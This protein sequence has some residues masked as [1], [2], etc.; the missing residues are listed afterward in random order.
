[1]LSVQLFVD[2]HYNLCYSPISSTLI[3]LF[4]SKT[5]CVSMRIST[6][7][8]NALNISSSNS[9]SSESLLFIPSRISSNLCFTHPSI[10]LSSLCFTHPSIT[11]SSSNLF[12]RT[13]QLI[14][15]AFVL[16]MLWGSTTPKYSLPSNNS[17]LGG[18]FPQIAYT[19]TQN[20]LVPLPRITHIRLKVY[21]RGSKKY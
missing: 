14:R 20:T 3:P 9:L 11:L 7:L 19:I 13:P 12:F 4:N 1:M 16:L 10:T 6:F 15:Y 18:L 8:T 21:P 17:F 2:T 5:K